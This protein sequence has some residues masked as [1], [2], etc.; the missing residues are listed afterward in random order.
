ME[1][2]YLWQRSVLGLMAAYH[3]VLGGLMLFSGDLTVKLIKLSMGA[4]IIQAPALGVVS[5]LLACYM[6]TF[7]LMIALAAVEPVKYRALISIGIVLIAIRLFQWCFFAEDTMPIF[8]VAPARFWT[9]GACLAAFGVCLS[10]FRWQINRDL[11]RGNPP[12]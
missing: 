8:K 11:P 6:L 1:K 7:G 4:N 10:I 3:L 9:G 2:T 12:S 5:E